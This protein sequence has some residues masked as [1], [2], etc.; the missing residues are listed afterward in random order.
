M[1]N[2][3]FY[4]KTM[5]YAM[6]NLKPKELATAKALLE[7]DY[8]LSTAQV[9]IHANVSWN[10]AKKYLEKMYQLHWI[11]KLERGNRDYW[12]AYRK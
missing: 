7:H 10:T 11:A 1:I 9:A 8:Y 5:Y 12:R 3:Y 6:H 2:T 4:Q